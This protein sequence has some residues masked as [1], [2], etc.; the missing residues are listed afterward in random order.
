MRSDNRELPLIG[1][2]ASMIEKIGNLPPGCDGLHA[3]GTLPREDYR[4][5][6]E[7]LFEQAHREG[8]RVRF[9][10]HFGPSFEG[11]TPGAAWEDVR[12]GLHY[13]RLFER[14]AVVSDN[15]WIRETTRMMGF[16]M[17]CPVAT[18]ANSEWGAAL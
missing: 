2:L 8:R 15:K 5:V 7:P 3:E 11:F 1:K 6:L 18:F 12:V 4:Q 16:L 10:Y 13:L 17:P 14:C 9:L